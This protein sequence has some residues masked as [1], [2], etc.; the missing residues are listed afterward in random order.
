MGYKSNTPQSGGSGPGG[1]ISSINGDTTAAQS[2]VGGTGI[3]VVTT[4]GITTVSNTGAG[5]G[6]VVGPAS[7]TA[8]AIAI[9]SGT[10]GKIIKNSAWIV[11]SGNGNLNAG[12]GQGSLASDLSTINLWDSSNAVTSPL[13]FSDGVLSWLDDMS[14]GGNFIVGSAQVGTALT[15][16]SV[17]NTINNSQQTNATLTINA[18]NTLGGGP[19]SMLQF[20]NVT[21]GTPLMGF[22]GVTP[23][24]A[25]T[26]N[27]ISALTNYGLLSSPTAIT[28]AQGG[29]GL[30]TLTTHGVMLGEGTGNVAFATVGTSGRLLIDQGASADPSFNVVSGDITISSS[31]TTTLTTVNTNVGSFTNANITVDGK[32][33]ITA[34]ANGSA[35]GAVSFNGITSGTNTAAAMVVGSGATLTAT[36]TG[37]IVATTLQTGRTI[38]ITG[39]LTYTSSAFDGSA[40]V[41]A[42]GTLKNTGTAGTYGQ[43]TTDAQGRVTAGATNDVAHGGTGLATLTAHAVLLGEGTSNIAFASVGTAGRMLIDQGAAADPSFNAMSGDATLVSTGVMTLKNTGTAGT[44]GQVTTDAQGRV[45]AGATNDVA[46]GGTGITSTTAYAVLTGGTTS[47]GALQSIA[48]VG[49]SGQVLTS[50]GAG[51]LPTFQA[52]IGGGGV[53]L[54]LVCAV[55]AGNLMP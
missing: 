25:P 32:G 18:Y 27:P 13:A 51:A 34:A 44:Y 46:H 14:V 2:I 21:S 30:A 52:A 49:T 26:G 6:N 12:V 17:A 11:D 37:T 38:A 31:G 22:N 35:G 43:V 19:Q 40:N 33:R 41:T 16:G 54:G 1:G 10:T 45:T 42:V 15:F 4:T 20:K 23:I 39:D 3:N 5:S 48:S 36:G 47:T 50:N 7:A 28:A 53:S 8:N 29:T 55:A 24:A 9:Y